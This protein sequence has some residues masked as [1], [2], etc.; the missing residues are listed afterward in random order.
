MALVQ[1]EA[2]V[3][4]VYCCFVGVPLLLMLLL[5]VVPE[6]AVDRTLHWVTSH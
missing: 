6:M 3:L 4:L 2:L 1:G 5:L